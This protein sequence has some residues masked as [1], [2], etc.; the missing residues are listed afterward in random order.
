MRF[1]LWMFLAALAI[2]G[3]SQTADKGIKFEQE[4]TWKAIQEKARKE[5]KYIFVDAFTTWCGPCKQMAKNIFPQAEVGAF[6]NHNF[7]NVKV[8][9]DTTAKD[10]DAVRRWYQDAHDI[11]VKNEVKVFPTYLF[12]SPTGKL[13]HRSV[14]SSDASAFI[15]KGKNALNPE[16]QYYT[17]AEK[18]NAGQRDSGFL[19]RLA[20]AALEA[21]DE[22]KIGT[23]AKAYLL[24]QSNWLTE[25]NMRFITSVT[26]SS[27]DTGFT[28]MLKHP[29]EFD[30]VMGAGM[31][32]GTTRMIVMQ[33][34]IFPVIFSQNPSEINWETL[35]KNVAAKFPSHGLEYAKY[36]KVFYFQ[37]QGDW[38]NFATSV[39]DFMEAFGSNTTPIEKNNFAWAIFENCDDMACIEKAIDWSRSA[40]AVKD[41]NYFD[42][43]ANLLYK[44][45]KTEAAIAAQE[46]TIALAKEV[47]SEN[48]PEF[49]V[50]LA[51]MKKGE[52]TW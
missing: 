28:L 23:Y 45:G 37:Q 27:R 40:T 52:K 10:D 16:T 7:I 15:A 34:E 2:N 49:E 1:T 47:K 18:Y 4:L 5:K 3:R 6:Y 42:T 39:V 50:N 36:A 46:Q 51:K 41:P 11:M 43:Y 14:G 17:L 22:R 9:L 33:E 19:R 26:F 20:N 13:V 35:E 24:T 29:E 25:E 44:S 48:L 31:A 38:E 30:K 32:K 8:Q 21:Y 12:F